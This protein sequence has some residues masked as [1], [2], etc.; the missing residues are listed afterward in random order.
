M[1]I[2]S[3]P[4]PRSDLTPDQMRQGI[5]RLERCTAMI[6]AF[7]PQTIQTPHDTWK[8][9]ELSASVDSTLVQTFGDDTAASVATRTSPKRYGQPHLSLVAAVP[10]ANRKTFAHSGLKAFALTRDQCKRMRNPSP[11]H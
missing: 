7:D 11:P 6:E 3:A 2:P 10:A 8:A 9:E 4:L 1:A 5:S